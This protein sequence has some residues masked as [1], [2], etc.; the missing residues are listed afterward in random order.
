MTQSTVL[1]TGNTYPVKDSIKALGGRWDAN[2]KGW[3]VPSAR[4]ADAQRLVAGAPKS[5]YSGARR[6][7]SG[8]GYRGKWTGC[9]C[10][11]IEGVERASDCASCK[12]DY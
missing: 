9:R 12:H 2:A 8:S 4:A 10:G 7:T 1:V 5:A 11:S 3:R 6:S